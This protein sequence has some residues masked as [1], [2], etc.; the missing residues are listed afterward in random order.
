MTTP[1]LQSNIKGVQLGLGEM[2]KR[3]PKYFQAVVGCSTVA[4]AKFLCGPELKDWRKLLVVCCQCN[5]GISQIPDVLCQGFAYSTE[6]CCICLSTYSSWSVQ[7][8]NSSF[9]VS[10]G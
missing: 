8:A 6:P 10:N 5:I 1:K 7:I 9:H 2:N 4:G 3:L